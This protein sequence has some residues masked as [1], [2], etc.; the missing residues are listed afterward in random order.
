MKTGKKIL[1][2]F[3]IIFALIIAILLGVFLWVKFNYMG[4]VN[5][6]TEFNPQNVSVNLVPF[7]NHKVT[8]IALLGLD[9]KRDFGD[10]KNGR[11]DAVM[12][13]TIDREHKKLKLSSIARDTYVKIDRGN[14]NTFN[15]KLTHAHSYGGAELAVKTINQ[16]FDMD[17]TD[18]VSV[19]YMQFVKLIDYIGGVEIDVD[20]SEMR[21]MNE[22]YTHSLRGVGVPCED[23]KAPGKQILT[24]SQALAYS[25]N[26]Y[27]P[28]GDVQR[29]NRQK[30][31][32]IA[33]YERVKKLDKL[34]DY[35][36]IIKMLCENCKT[37]LT[38]YEI[39]D[40]A[41]WTAKNLPRIESF[42]LPTSD[43]RPKS[44]NDAMIN[45]TW[46]YIY[47]LDTATENLH[48]FIKEN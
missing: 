23:I 38:D 15:D 26:R 14:G 35:D 31:V 30:E 4:K 45:G 29:G 25:R 6:D 8:N 12:I 48:S 5:T 28:G 37:S 13:L 20:E 33:A 3:I 27:S 44:G 21:V 10:G 2:T 34:L 47:D 11:S 17:I 22:N 36:H 7:E 9:I 18:Y 1:I 32:L 39:L 43:C 19:N 46:Y 16:N 42:S 24:G 41:L 40:I